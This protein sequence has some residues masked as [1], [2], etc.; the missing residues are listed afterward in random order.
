[1]SN[2]N[3]DSIYICSVQIKQEEDGGYSICSLNLP[4]VASQG[5]TLDDAIRNIKEA[6]AGCVETYLENGELPQTVNKLID[7]GGIF[8]VLV[9]IKKTM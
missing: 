5:D 7:K 6:F 1:M 3:H 8:D 4:G 9:D 2:N